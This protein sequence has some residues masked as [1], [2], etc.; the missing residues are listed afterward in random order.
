MASRGGISTSSIET[1]G[2]S[3]NNGFRSSRRHHPRRFEPAQSP[4]WGLVAAAAVVV[5][6]FAVAVVVAV[7]VVVEV[8]V[9]SLHYFGLQFTQQ[10][11]SL[12]AV[13]FQLVVESHVFPKISRA[14]TAN[15]HKA[16]GRSAQGSM[17]QGLREIRRQYGVATVSGCFKSISQTQGS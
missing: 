4:K 13:Q 16:E 2:G 10:P 1:P 3:A 7:M 15:T 17:Y 12:A 8:V 14:G 6:S 9:R 5:M 11:S